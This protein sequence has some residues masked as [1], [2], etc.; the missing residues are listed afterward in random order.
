[1]ASSTN[2]THAEQGIPQLD[3]DPF[4]AAALREPYA[5][6]ERLRDAGCVVWL[7]RYETYGVARHAELSQILQKPA[8]FSSAAGVG[9]AHLRRPGAW[10]EPS[11][12]VESDPPQHDVIRRAMDEILTPSV[13]R[14]WRELFSSEAQRLCHAALD[15][16]R[17]DGV[18]DLAQR[19]VHAVFPAALGVESNPDNLLI[20]G[21]H[22]AN[23]AGPRNELF[24]E[25]QAAL[26]SIK[27][28]YLRQQTRDA[29]MPGGFGERVFAAEARGAMPAGTAG[30]VL[31]TLLRGGLDTTI[32][33]IA[34]T[35]WLLAK[36]PDRWQ[37]L[38]DDPSLA[39][40]AFEEALRLES[41][42]PSIYRTT[43]QSAE[44]SGHLLAPD[45]KVQL[46]IGAANRDPRR[47]P[48]ADVFNP[49]RRAKN[50]LIFGGGPHH[51]LGQRIARLEAD[52]FLGALVG[53]V[54]TL[55]LDGQPVWRAV[56]MLRTLESLPL[57]VTLN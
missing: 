9:L 38:R 48:D 41:P 45:T 49:A 56:N 22:S 15:S 57:R 32:S 13:I 53:R 28:W 19:Y 39:A 12:L 14:G 54:A 10:R 16:G 25:S 40:G 27:D 55:S 7:E 6:Q 31:R 5:L 2:G 29:M 42:T 47:W 51:C 20:V 30:P 24:H 21:H 8:D 50:S 46:F 36:H 11:P 1:M 23:A 37:A 18:T 26:E 34:S 35:L 3:I 17:I 52:C 44:I 33:G 4:D 43:T